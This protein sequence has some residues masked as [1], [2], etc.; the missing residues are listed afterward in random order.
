MYLVEFDQQNLSSVTPLF[1]PQFQPMQLIKGDL[2]QIEQQLAAFAGHEGLP[3]W[4]DI[5][6]ATQDYLTDIQRRIQALAANLPVEVVL[7]RRSKEQ[8]NNSIHRQEKETLNE[9]TVSDVF[10]RR[11]ALEADLPEP[12]Q[13][14]MRQMFNYVVDEIAQDGSNGVAEEPAQ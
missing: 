3:V 14:R 8:R 4:L 12:R 7:L 13:Q 11:L 9:L 10:E 2:R 5:E 6:V 1:I